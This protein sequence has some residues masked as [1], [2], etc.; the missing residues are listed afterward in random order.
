[1]TDSK[2]ASEN[3]C[4]CICVL[5]HWFALSCQETHLFPRF[6]AEM[7][8]FVVPLHA[9][10]TSTAVY[11]PHL[12]LAYRYASILVAQ[13]TPLIQGTGFIDLLIVYFLKNK[14][15]SPVKRLVKISNNCQL[16]AACCLSYRQFVEF[17]LIN[18]SKRKRF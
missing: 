3:K 12:R 16:K 8:K 1:M 9:E 5:R 15:V 2:S 4:L 17:T 11:L 10:A 13:T 7:R 6:I 14:G 18:V